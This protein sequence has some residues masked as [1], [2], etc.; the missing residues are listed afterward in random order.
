MNESMNERRMICSSKFREYM[1]EQVIPNMYS[2][3]LMD[4]KEV[5]RRYENINSISRKEFDGMWRNM[6]PI[7]FRHETKKLIKNRGNR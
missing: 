7:I 5:L 4:T 1:Y 2:R 3:G 6:V